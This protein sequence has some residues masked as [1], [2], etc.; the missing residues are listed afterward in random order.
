[1]TAHMQM[2]RFDVKLFEHQSVYDVI[3]KTR[4]PCDPTLK[5]RR[6]WEEVC[7]MVVNE[8]IKA[9]ETAGMFSRSAQNLMEQL[10]AEGQGL[11]IEYMEYLVSTGKYTADASPGAQCT[12]VPG[13]LILP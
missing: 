12:S 7:S 3:M 2:H 13:R 11:A 5:H 10:N 1:M 4:I 8:V 9:A 6:E